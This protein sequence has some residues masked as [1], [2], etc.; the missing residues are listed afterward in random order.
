MNTLQDEKIIFIICFF[1]MFMAANNAEIIKK[2]KQ[3]SYYCQQGVSNIPDP[4]IHQYDI[5]II[6][7]SLTGF[8]T[9]I[10]ALRSV[11]NTAVISEVHPLRL[12][13]VAA[14]GST[15]GKRI[16]IQADTSARK[17]SH[18]TSPSSRHG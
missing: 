5:I 14:L 9:A 17:V 12:H 15:P 2:H 8:R 1:L 7:K 6:R 11:F 4:A 13:S 3:H 16:T 18:P 10:E